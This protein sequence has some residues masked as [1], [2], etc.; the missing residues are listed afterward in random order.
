M[1]SSRWARRSWTRAERAGARIH[2]DAPLRS[3]DFASRQ[4]RVGA[5]D[6]LRELPFSVLLGADGAGSALRQ[7][8]RIDLTGKKI[9]FAPAKVF[10][11]LT[12]RSDSRRSSQKVNSRASRDN[13][14]KRAR[15]AKKVRAASKAI[16]T[17][18]AIG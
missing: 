4:I 3:V 7:A 18:N 10:N 2:F 14:V 13:K 9:E 1:G 15:A 12:L 5:D 6:R 8:M 16:S 11:R 17:V